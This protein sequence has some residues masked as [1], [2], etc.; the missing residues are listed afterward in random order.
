MEKEFRNT[1][2][3]NT[4]IVITTILSVFLFEIII[5]TNI[6]IKIAYTINPMTGFSQILAFSVAFVFF[7][8]PF[9]SIRRRIWKIL[10][11]VTSIKGFKL[12][13]TKL[14]KPQEKA[15]NGVVIH[16]D[17]DLASYTNKVKVN[18]QHYKIKIK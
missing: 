12:N 7:G 1:A 11:S 13:L 14:P 3:Q 9:K 10:G 6:M 17:E 16:V 4:I 15:T 8:L 2:L 5:K 18:N